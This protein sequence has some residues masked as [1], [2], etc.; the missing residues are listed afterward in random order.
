MYTTYRPWGW[1]DWSLELAPPRLWTFIGCVGPEERSIVAATAFQKRNLLEHAILLR[2]VE[3]ESPFADLAS[4]YICSRE[5]SCRNA[6]L[7]ADILQLDLLTSITALDEVCDAASGSV[8]LDITSL[9]KRFFFY[10]LKQFAKNRRVRDLLVTYT[11]PK[12]YPE[13]ALAGNYDD[14]QALP[15]FRPADPDAEK[16]AQT[17]LIVNIGF[18]PNG[19]VAHLGGPADERKIDLLIPFPAPAETVRRIW[20][21]VWALRRPTDIRIREVRVAANDLSEAFNVILSL[22]P[23]GTGLVSFAPFGPKPISAAMCLYATLTGCP[24][25]YAQPKVYR[26]NYSIGVARVDGNP[27]IN[28]YWIKHEGRSLYALPPGLRRL[29]KRRRRAAAIYGARS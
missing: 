19:L 18:L 1:L 7:R 23:E 3:G 2:I 10:L 9:P 25:Y 11:S 8:V 17:R 24:V 15:S 13:G 12:G 27:A 22:V 20:K 14:W 4:K 16:Q 21:A 28:G 6:K 29:K 26:P 5:R